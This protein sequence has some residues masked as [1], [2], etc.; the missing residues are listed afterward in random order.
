M[1]GFERGGRAGAFLNAEGRDEGL[2]GLFYILLPVQLSRPFLNARIVQGRAISC[3]PGA[4]V[5]SDLQA[6]G[7]RLI[8]HPLH[9]APPYP[10]PLAPRR[11]HMFETLPI[12]P[13]HASQPSPSPLTLPAQTSAVPAPDA[14][15]YVNCCQKRKNSVSSS[16]VFLP[17]FCRFSAAVLPRFSSGPSP[18]RNRTPPLLG[19][20]PPVFGPPGR[21]PAWSQQDA[22][23]TVGSA[24]IPRSSWIFPRFFTTDFS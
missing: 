14:F 13:S 17:F 9:A 6:S 11:E 3:M 8:D 22:A 18:C 7:L 2:G 20:L 15:D 4:C 24:R 23:R 16:A 10:C 5:R 1:G 12:S 21:V 19:P